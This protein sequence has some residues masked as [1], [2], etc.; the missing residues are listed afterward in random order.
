MNAIVVGQEQD[1]V[2]DFPSSRLGERLRNARVALDMDLGKAARKL[3]LTSDMVEAI[4]CDDYSEMPARVFVRGYIRNYARLV[5]LPAESIMGQFDILW[6]EDD[7][8]L[9]VDHAPRLASDTSPGG[10]AWGS[11]L[12]WLL[13]A[14]GF[15][16]F[17]LWWLGHLDG[18]INQTDQAASP[19]VS[20]VPTVQDQVE[21]SESGSLLPASRPE[22]SLAQ[23]DDPAPAAP[24]VLNLPRPMLVVPDAGVQQAETPVASEQ[25]TDLE[26]TAIEPALEPGRTES[27]I[28]VSSAE[29]AESITTAEPPLDS[30]VDSAPAAESTP[31][32]PPAVQPQVVRS[33][34]KVVFN[35]DCWVDIRSKDRE[36]RLF[37]T[38]RKGSERVLGGEAPYK[39]ILGNASA[40]ALSVDG[41]PFD[42][43]PHTRENIARLT[44]S[45]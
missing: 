19:T 9:K 40:V 25:P 2:A 4:E 34:V 1:N 11:F 35:E 45:L 36:F 21:P 41:K 44:L 26:Q 33:E 5:D 18:L 30:A 22:V 29:V 23:Q 39:M 27:E 17:V 8:A 3:H 10:G 28:L 43:A 6:P 14:G 20:T 12:T 24:G 31:E 38:M 16:L 7:N 13:V 42:L 37:G 15:V 32:V